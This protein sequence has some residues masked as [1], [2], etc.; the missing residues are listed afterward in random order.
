MTKRNFFSTNKKGVL[1]YSKHTKTFFVKTER[2]GRSAV[3][4]DSDE[5]ISLFLKE[6]DTYVVLD[7][8]DIVEDKIGKIETRFIVLGEKY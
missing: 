7:Y 3:I 8:V 4:R 6:E 2:K 5:T 1:D